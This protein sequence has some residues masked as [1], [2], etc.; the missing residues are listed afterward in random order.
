MSV[1]SEEYF[2]VICNK[3]FALHGV[4]RQGVVEEP[5]YTQCKNRSAL[6]FA[7]ESLLYTHREANGT[8]WN[9]LE[10][11]KALEHLLLQ[12]YKWSLSEI[13]ALSLAD[14][15]LLLQDELSPNNL[16]EEAKLLLKMYGV[17]T[18][19]KVFPGFMEDEWDPELYLTI[20][21]QQNW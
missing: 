1:I 12:K 9:P 18:A 21:K 17:L 14:T 10:G 4:A 20:P 7:L 15:V 5:Q 6:I 19:R 13:R 16:P 8:V 3:I 2:D 11:R